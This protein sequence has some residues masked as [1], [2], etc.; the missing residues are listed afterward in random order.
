MTQSSALHPCA[1]CPVRMNASA[2]DRETFAG[3]HLSHLGKGYRMLEL[4]QGKQVVC[5][6]AAARK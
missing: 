3:L 2:A 6:T 4:H 5:R 1:L